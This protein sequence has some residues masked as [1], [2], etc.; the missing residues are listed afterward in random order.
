[1]GFVAVAASLADPVGPF[2]SATKWEKARAALTATHTILSHPIMMSAT[3]LIHCSL[4]MCFVLP[5]K[6][7][8]RIA[9]YTPSIANEV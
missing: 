3:Q 9:G 1:M 5:S 2:F 6:S 4:F 8:R 7:L